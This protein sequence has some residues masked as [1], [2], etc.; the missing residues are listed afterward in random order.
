MTEVQEAPTEVVE[1]VEVEHAD[2][3]DSMWGDKP[4]VL[5]PVED[6]TEVVEAEPVIEATPEE[7]PPVVENT[8]V[9]P[10]DPYAWIE[11][12]PEEQREMASRLKHEALSDRGR[13]SALTRKVTEITEELATT[14]STSTSANEEAAVPNAPELS[15]NFKQLQE[16]YPEL[17][18][19]LSSIWSERE[20]SL[21]QEFSDQIAPIQEAQT[22]D[23][24][25]SEKA[26]LDKE[27]SDIFNTEETG[28]YWEDVV[29]SED[30]SNWL[31]NQPSFIQNTAR[32]SNAAQ[33]GIDV[34]RMYE[35]D[36]QALVNQ[37]NSDEAS[38]TATAQGDK[39]KAK[40]NQ[41]KATTVSP[42]SKPVGTETDGAAGDYD[43]MFNAQWGRKKK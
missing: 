16:D 8:P 4:E 23:A 38:Q 3:F 15:D 18:K 27:A 14:R 10:R 7:V 20:A 26:Q 29:K 13:V 42:A 2:A 35:T 36:Y 25:A 1:E 6:V 43:S 22:A 39:V 5:E 28:I 11:G 41:R 33:D 17:G 31:S 40:R 34:L 9:A 19:Q 37:Q 21:R 32:T 30:F 24:Q 12:L